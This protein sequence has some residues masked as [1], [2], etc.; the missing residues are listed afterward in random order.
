M[1][2]KKNDTKFLILLSFITLVLIVISYIN[3]S[4]ELNVI[5]KDVKSA[6]II[7]ANLLTKYIYLLS[8]KN[9][10]M[11]KSIISNYTKAKKNLLTSEKINSI[12]YYKEQNIYGLSPFGDNE[13]LKELQGTLTMIDKLYLNDK[14]LINELTAVLSIDS[15][16]ET[17]SKYVNESIWSYY[18][19][20]SNFM[21]LSPAHKIKD[22]QFNKELYNKPF[23]SQAKPS[24]NKEHRQIISEVYM[25]GAG[26]GMMITISN[27][28][29]IHDK[30]KG[31]ISIDLG[32]KEL[33]SLLNLEQ[34]TIGKS[35]LVDENKQ[36]N[37]N[38]EENIYIES[39]DS[40]GVWEENNGEF[41]YSIP[42]VED[43]L[44]IVHKL[45]K[46]ELYK[47][48]FLSSL[49]IN[50]ML[51]TI[52][53]VI[54]FSFFLYK[55]AKKNKELMQLDSLTKLYNRRGFYTL[56]EPIFAYLQRMDKNYS[57]IIVDIDFFK[58]VN[59]TYGHKI[60]DEVIQSISHILRSL[61]RKDTLCARWGGEEF[62]V[63]VQDVDSKI[64]Q[65]I[66]TRI[67][68]SINSIKHSQKNLTITVSIGT[69]TSDTSED[70]ETVFSKA[71]E[72]LYR[73][74]ETGRN[75]TISC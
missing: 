57:V 17:I 54:Y 52:A 9:I 24:V 23:W 8:T 15:Q 31:V 26:K 75:K 71:D 65:T 63:F 22:F 60:G 53:I 1:M 48:A 46:L 38:I 64:T 13:T 35:Y 41:S 70:F 44:Y 43:E 74:K 7:R 66:T 25:D 6:V 61:N 14:E 67:H 36:L 45:Q 34:N 30:F 69:C 55:S 47:S 33:R 21:Y 18:T 16:F 20:K 50:G 10:A 62:L 73:A 39:L 59:D 2:T 49:I 3:F 42:V 27:P 32:I 11:Q 12:K 40:K 68:N 72:A 5:K 37:I 56:I 29:F 28:I 4:Y 51:F 58:K 19:S